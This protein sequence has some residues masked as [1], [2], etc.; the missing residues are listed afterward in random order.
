MSKDL[1]ELSA[2][3]EQKRRELEDLRAAVRR[4]Q[5]EIA[6]MIATKHALLRDSQQLSFFRETEESGE[7][8]FGTSGRRA[9]RISSEWNQILNYFVQRAPSPVSIDEVMH[10][11]AQNS[12]DVSRNSVRS[13]LH[14]YAQRHAL[15]RVGDGYYRATNLLK[16]FC[17]D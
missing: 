5:S 6:S 7:N 9:R 15:E 13:Q 16:D 17:H 14:N 2:Q 3:I 12:F 1:N 4:L 10:F 11:I 8:R